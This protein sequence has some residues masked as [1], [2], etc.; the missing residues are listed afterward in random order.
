[1]GDGEVAVVEMAVTAVRWRG[2]ME[3]KGERK[4]GCAIYKRVREH[5]EAVH[6]LA[7]WGRRR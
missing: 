6:A 4:T 1:M 5:R 3:K 2:E 7:S